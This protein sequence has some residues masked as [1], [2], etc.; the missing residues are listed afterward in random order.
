MQMDM[1]TSLVED[2][3][4]QEYHARGKQCPFP[5]DDLVCLRSNSFGDEEKADVFVP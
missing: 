2:L 5:P 3:L 4:E 1:S